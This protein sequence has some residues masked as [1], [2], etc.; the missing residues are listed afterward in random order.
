L[1]QWFST[2]N[3]VIKRVKSPAFKKQSNFKMT[4]NYTL[5]VI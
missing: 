4:T 1:R 3:S 2:W 5:E